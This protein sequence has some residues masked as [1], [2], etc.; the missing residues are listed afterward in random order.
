MSISLLQ[1]SA[2]PVRWLRQALGAVT[3]LAACFVQSRADM[4]SDWNSIA[5][6]VFLNSGRPGGAVIVD[7]AYV[8]I[9]I[10]DAVNAI[11]GRYT[12]FAVAPSSAAPWASKEA[13]VAAAAYGVLAALYPSQQ[14]YLNSAYAHSLVDVRDDESKGRGIAIGRE[15]AEKFLVL[16]AN[17][18]RNANVPYTFLTG[19]GVYQL[20]P[21]APPPPATPQ[22]P[23]LAH[24]KPFAMLSPDQFRAPGPPTL[25]SDLFARDFKEIKMYGAHDGS[26]RSL[27][28]TQ[29]GQFYAENPGIQLSRN[30]RLFASARGMSLADNAR[31][32]AQIYA[33]IAD[34]VI[35]GWDSKYHYN[36]WRPVTAIRAGDTD[37]NPQTDPDTSWLPLVTTPG[38]PEYPAAHGCVTG[39]LA[40]ALEKFFGTKNVDITLTSTSVSG[41]AS[42]EHHFGD[43]NDIVTE[44]INAR[45]YGGLHYR[46][47]GEQGAAIAHNVAEWVASNKF[48]PASIPTAGLQLWLRPDAGVVLNGSGVSTW[49]DQSG[50]GNDASQA[51]PGRQ[52]QLVNNALNG[53]P[54]M[55]FDGQD[56]RLGLT[57][58]TPMSQISL[59]FVFKPDSGLAGTDN[60]DPLPYFPIILGDANFAGRAYGLSM[61]N[62]FSGNSPD[63][64]DPWTSSVSWVHATTHNAAAFGQWKILSAVTNETMWN[65]SVRVN[66]VDAAITP[67]PGVNTP[68]LV[69]LGTPAGTSGIGGADNVPAGHLIFEG[70]IA[71]VIVYDTALTDSVRRAVESYLNTKYQVFGSPQ[72]GV[73]GRES[74]PGTFQLMQNYPN[75]FNPSTKIYF[76]IPVSGFVTMTVFDVLGRHVTTLVNE[77]LHAGTYETTFNAF[78]LSSGVYFYKLQAGTFV[79]TKRLLLLR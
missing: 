46:T 16:R 7:M 53:Q 47:S 66:G 69:P 56:D 71:E 21:G 55:H 41:I 77:N 25:S 23:W 30:M 45:V 14:V 8:H 58:S 44:V 39:G 9:A 49:T 61:R 2:Q 1:R 43:I 35:A 5:N 22:T 4:V 70:D 10:Y 26:A 37:G 17:D 50:N 57:G 32:F 74:I 31:L 78:G 38:H 60:T 3:I 28:Q 34:A 6:T 67:Q 40:Y 73:A 15:V 63:I 19:P 65:T 64:I 51:N 72:T 54:V 36:F 11:D 68:L 27:A 75:P 33:T 29:I 12:Q 52:P 18:G 76:R 59:F 20:T 13:A 24:L 42:A 48:K 79:E 62:F